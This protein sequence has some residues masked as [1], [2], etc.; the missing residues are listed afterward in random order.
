MSHGHFTESIYK[1]MSQLRDILYPGQR[2]SLFEDIDRLEEENFA[3]IDFFWST[4][5]RSGQVGT[6]MGLIYAT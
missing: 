4:L 3:W 2:Q 6:D 1:L 5:G